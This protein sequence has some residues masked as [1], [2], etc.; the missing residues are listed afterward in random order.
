MDISAA[1]EAFRILS[2]PSN[3]VSAFNPNILISST[4]L[5]YKDLLNR[6]PLYLEQHDTHE[7]VALALTLLQ[8]KSDQAIWGMREKG[9]FRLSRYDFGESVCVVVE[10]LLMAGKVCNLRKDTLDYLYSIQALHSLRLQ[11]KPIFSYISGEIERSKSTVL[12]STFVVIDRMFLGGWSGGDK[13]HTSDHPLHHSM[14]DFAEAFSTIIRIYKNRHGLTV[15]DWQKA[16]PDGL[17]DSNLYLFILTAAAQLNAFKQAEVMLD[18]LPYGA[19]LVGGNVHIFSSDPLFEKTVRLGYVQQEKQSE[20]RT[21]KIAQLYHSSK[22]KMPS[23]IEEAKRL[24]DAGLKDF[25]FVKE[26]PVRRLVFAI[27]K[28][29]YVENIIG[30]AGLFLEEALSMMRLDV[31]EF[32]DDDLLLREVKPG[33][34]ISHILRAQRFFSFLACIYEMALEKLP[35]N[36]RKFIA[37]QSVINIV[38]RE[39]VVK[40]LSIGMPEEVAQEIISM[41]SLPVEGD[42]IDIQYFPLI[43]ASSDIVYSARVLSASNIVRNIYVSNRLHKGWKTGCDP[44][45]IKLK[46]AFLQA[47]FRVE[48]EVDLPFGKDLDAD[49]LAYKDGMLLLLECKHIYHPC[50]MHELRNT[51]WHIEKGVSQLNTRVPF[52]SNQTHLDRLL[53]QVGWN[54]V[55]VDDIRGAI[56]TSTRVLHGWCAGGYPVVQANEFI[57]VLTRGEIIG[58]E[59]DY[60]F[61]ED[62]NLTVKD[63]GRYLDRTTIIEDQ[64]NNLEPRLEVHPYG[65]SQLIYETWSVNEDSFAA[66]LAKK[67][68]FTPRKTN[69]D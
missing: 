1:Y 29:S 15:L 41:L 67:Y 33:I 14:E 61:W 59:G 30:Y 43:P 10:K 52:L 23:L 21:Q 26:E 8:A 17:N 57:N 27:P 50:N 66:R 44:M 37:A 42:L 3:M 28:I 69:K 51:L 6:L 4:R 60:R 68:K 9:F 31:D 35:E 58:P 48:I 7:S 47:G 56:I 13:N 63:V 55:T 64:L 20:I 25:I 38:P 19:K 54:G 34:N 40:S 36:E 12:K 24:F 53:R 18:G 2:T 11:A 46:S 39:G 49:I 62:D 45:V 16:D 22:R 65:A 5:L 32:S